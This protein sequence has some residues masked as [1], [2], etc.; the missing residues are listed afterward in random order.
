MLVLLWESALSHDGY[1]SWSSSS[2]QML[3]FLR[4]EFSVRS[5]KTEPLSNNHCVCLNIVFVVFTM[6]SIPMKESFCGEV[7]QWKYHLVKQDLFH[8]KRPS[9]IWFFYCVLF[10][11][12]SFLE[13]TPDS[14]MTSSRLQHYSGFV[15][16]RRR[17]ENLYQI[18]LH[19]RIEDI[20]WKME[21]TLLVVMSHERG[22]KTEK[23]LYWEDT[24][25][26][27]EGVSLS[28]GFPS[29]HEAYRERE[30]ERERKSAKWEASHD[31]TELK[32]IS[33]HKLRR[34]SLTTNIRKGM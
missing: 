26:E 15:R 16:M 33:R 18:A 11:V 8:R 1:S 34:F 21:V 4:L 27:T 6:A 32:G 2:F 29:I 17:E 10:H 28:K 31:K 5:A 23:T 24:N 25:K 20:S 14:F 3:S 12:S 19:T 30:R 22:G 7:K 9:R 13:N